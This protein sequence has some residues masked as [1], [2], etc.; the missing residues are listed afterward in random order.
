[1]LQGGTSSPLIG[2]ADD[3]LDLP[4]SPDKEK[5]PDYGYLHTRRAPP[6]RP[7]GLPPLNLEMLKRRSREIQ[8]API[9]CSP[10]L[11][12]PRVQKP[13]AGSPVTR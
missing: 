13:S 8:E 3:E 2:F 4:A 11:L 10:R 6:P 7:E 1:M 9:V 5:E 12:S